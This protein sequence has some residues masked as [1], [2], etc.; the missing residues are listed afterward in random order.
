MKG[1]SAKAG[2]VYGSLHITEETYVDTE[3]RQE[4]LNQTQEEHGTLMLNS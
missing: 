2:S 3:Q 1:K 4:V